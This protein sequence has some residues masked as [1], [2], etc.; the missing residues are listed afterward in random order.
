M[1]GSGAIIGDL[2]N[3]GGF[4]T[5]GHSTGMLG[6][7]GSFTQTAAG[8]LI[9]E[10][11]GGAN[12]QFD[13]LLVGE[14]A[15]LNGNLVLHTIDAYLPL[16]NDPFAPMT[17][18]SV[19]GS[20]SSITSNCS[21]NIAGAGLVVVVDPSKPNPPFGQPTNI[22]TRMKVLTDDNVLIGGFIVT[23]PSGSTKKVLIHG[24][25]PSLSSVHLSGLL[26]DPYLEFHYPDGT[27]LTNDNWG[28]APNK[29]QIPPG[30][31]LKDP[32]ES[33]LILDLPPA[34]YTVIVKGAHGETGIGMTE[35]YD[36]DGNTTTSLSNVSTRGFVDTGDNVM[37]GGFI[38]S[39]NEPGTMLVKA[40]GPSLKNPPANLTGVLE[41]PMLELHDSN[42][43]VITNDNWR[44]SQESEIMATGMAPK[45]DKEPAILATLA[46]GVYTAIVRGKN[47]TT[48]IAIVEAY[49]IK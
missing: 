20:F 49:R 14:N 17:Y 46:P 5:P 4:V 43:N 45:D 41:D 44:E 25:G 1:S 26:S 2:T 35:V 18:G 8:A 42:G 13:Q 31:E 10:A 24:L 38:V 29:D 28:D 16:P 11:A 19:T 33:V 36:I 6:V 9:M 32:K 22:S 47:E 34:V 3:D 40:P 37:I 27:I 23:G 30:Y 48:G 12:G 15:A 21:L 7:T 39:G